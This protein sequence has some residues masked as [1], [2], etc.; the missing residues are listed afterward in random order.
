MNPEENKPQLENISES[1]EHAN[2]PKTFLD[3]IRKWANNKAMLAATIVSLSGAAA[4]DAPVDKDNAGQVDGNQNEMYKGCEPFSMCMT[5][6]LYNEQTSERI[7][8][9]FWYK[10]PEG[11]EFEDVTFKVLDRDGNILGKEKAF[12][13]S[14]TGEFWVTQPG[15]DGDIESDQASTAAGI[16][17]AFPNGETVTILNGGLDHPDDD[18]PSIGQ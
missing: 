6:G 17:V 3:K 9:S 16:E 4:C 2:E 18:A 14:G 11:Q 15:Y 5:T 12:L 7:G 13:P 10:V 1:A 8:F